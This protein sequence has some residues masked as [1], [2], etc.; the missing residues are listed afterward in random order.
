[1]KVAFSARPDE[2]NRHLGSESADYQAAPDSVWRYKARR[3]EESGRKSPLLLDMVPSHPTPADL[4]K[5]VGCNK[6]NALHHLPSGFCARY[7]KQK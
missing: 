7:E 2:E 4:R 1:M 3:S 5:D 6:R